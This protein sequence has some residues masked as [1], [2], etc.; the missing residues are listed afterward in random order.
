MPLSTGVV[1][2]CV[3][4][5]SSLVFVLD[6]EQYP[7]WS[8]FLW[9]FAALVRGILFCFNLQVDIINTNVL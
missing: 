4:F 3:F 9:I 1:L 7:V 8:C 2:A 5:Y 6:D